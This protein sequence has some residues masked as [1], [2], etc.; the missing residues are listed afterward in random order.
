MLVACMNVIGMSACDVS[1]SLC[2]VSSC[3]SDVCV[4]E[5]CDWIV[6]VSGERAC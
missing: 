4:R 6:R 3:M 5:A 2:K 1:V